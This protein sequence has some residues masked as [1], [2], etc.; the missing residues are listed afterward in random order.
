MNGPLQP[1]LYGKVRRKRRSV[2][3]MGVGREMHAIKKGL[4]W[5]QRE[6]LFSRWKE[7]YF[8][9][10]RDYLHCFKRSSGP[11]K[12]SDMGQFIFKVKLVEVESV[13]WVNRKTY[14]VIALV[15]ANRESKILLRAAQGLEDWF[16][17]LEEC[18]MTSKERRKALRLY[19]NAFYKDHSSTMGDSD[20]LTS[21]SSH[22]DD[23]LLSRNPASLDPSLS[24]S[25]PDLT[26]YRPATRPTQ[27]E[28]AL[29]STK[30]NPSPLHNRLSLLTDIDINY[31]D[32]NGSLKKTGSPYH[33]PHQNSVPP[34]PS[35]YV[36]GNVFF[37]PASGDVRFQSS[38]PPSSFCNNRPVLTPVG[39]F[40]NSPL[41]SPVRHNPERSISKRRPELE[42]S[43]C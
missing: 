6:R 31:C 11:D 13:E 24:D 25:V 36:N 2:L 7:R 9:L 29:W 21:L 12:I 40:R 34:S 10:T 18:T 37:L 32:T 19:G 43:H 28:H 5:Q 41:F 3:S 1:S 23:W 39:S 14:S 26:K 22:V 38:G 35:P 42:V 16:E 33:Y 4:L 27:K 30:H 8:I 15:L 17:L 20:H